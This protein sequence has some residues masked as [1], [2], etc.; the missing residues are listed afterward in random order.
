MMHITAANKHK[1]TRKQ[2]T[3]SQVGGIPPG[4]VYVGRPSQWENPAETGTWFKFAGTWH[5]VK[6]DRIATSLF[7]EI[8]KRKAQES[9]KEFALWLLPLKGR[10]LCCR[11]NL[12]QACHADVLLFL[13]T[14]LKFEN[15]GEPVF[16]SPVF[17]PPLA[18][19]VQGWQ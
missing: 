19:I 9:P 17:W 6:D 12:S 7:Y 15:S 1:P 8:C 3:R 14:L 11:C 2:R 18:E 16:E 10:D 4:S 13:V 5:N